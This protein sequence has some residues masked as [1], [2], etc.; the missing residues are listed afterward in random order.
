MT[1]RVDSFEY[2]ESPKTATPRGRR[3]K[4]VDPIRTMLR[5]EGSRLG[6]AVVLVSL[7]AM[8]ELLPHFVV[9][10]VALA[11]FSPPVEPYRLYVLAAV[12]FAGVLI[13]F[14]LLGAGYIVSH[15]V[16]FRILHKLRLE[17]TDKL[18]RVPMSFFAEHPSGDLK[19]TIV[20]DVAS[21][22]SVAAH[23][24]PE[25]ASGVFVPVVAA[26]VL[27]ASDWRLG[28]AGLALLPI[29][30]VV[31]SITMSGYEEGWRAWHD[32]ESQANGGVLEFIRGIAVLKA[33][34]RDAS[35]LARVRDGI[36]GIR[37]LATAMTR[38]TMAGYSL[39]MGLLDTNLLVV[40]PVGLALHLAGWIAD[41]QLVLFV[42]L[43]TGMLRP[44]LRLLFLFGEAQKIRTASERI[45]TVLNA[46]ELSEPDGV[47]TIA[48]G[49]EVCVRGVTFRYP[50]RDRPAVLD[51]SFDL[52]FGTVTAVV[53][54]SGAGKTTLARLL[55]RAHDVDDGIISVSGSDLR[56]L[57]TRQ[58]TSLI[59][60]VSQDT[61]LFDGSVRDNLL[62]ARPSASSEELE[63]AAKA[64][65]AHEFVE[66]LPD[67]YDTP[68]GDRGSRLSGGERQRLAIAR[69]LLKGA[70]I[71]VL[72]EP[73]ANVDPQSERGIQ[74]GISALAQDRTVLVVAHRLRSVAGADQIL[75][76]DGG[77]LVDAGKHE[78]LVERCSTYATLW[79]DQEDAMRWSL[80]GAS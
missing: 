48:A 32:A 10:E 37:D 79:R 78:E 55:V 68:L 2:V 24:L 13:R 27:F 15:T 42:A 19:K 57:S 36:Y 26:G 44:L 8:L 65:H 59:G 1:S 50:G 75:V 66:N 67:G 5:S 73:T 28:L 38:R 45:S 4:P 74:E 22:E 30:F 17:L 72:D 49:P 16:A 52:P 64:A 61:T 76:M 14:F 43:G 18:R 54:P 39:F 33:F 7:S 77:R 40:L 21:L 56:R 23:N 41:D 60:H 31:Q 3:S 29:A 9:Y 25:F 70:P 69:A 62:L 34:D 53:G 58:R 11:V 63:A 46:D 80:K 12:A 20:D 6:L 71:V 35:S 51:V 47:E